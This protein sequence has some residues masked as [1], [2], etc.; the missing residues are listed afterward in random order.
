MENVDVDENNAYIY[1]YGRGNG[2]IIVYNLNISVDI[3]YP[4]TTQSG[5][6]TTYNYDY[7]IKI[8]KPDK[9]I[10]STD[11]RDYIM[12]TRCGS[13]MV[14]AVKTEATIHP[15]NI[16][17][18]VAGANVIKYT[19]NLG[20]PTLIFGYIKVDSGGTYGLIS[21]TGKY[22]YVPAPLQS[23]AFP[24]TFTNGIE[25]FIG[26]DTSV[27][28]GASIIVLRNPSIAATNSVEVTY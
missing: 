4:Y 14:L 2:Y 20:Y 10:E 18:V 28:V 9:N 25:T 22:L 3:E 1:N 11:M 8:A 15:D 17:P 24:I 7:G 5:G 19:H 21:Y 16:G 23:Q 6:N 27:A 26:Y 13:P 12:H